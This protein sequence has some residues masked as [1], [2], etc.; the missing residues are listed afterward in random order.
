[1]NHIL[2]CHEVVKTD[3]VRG[4]GRYLYDAQG[5]RYV[6]FETGAWCTPLGHGTGINTTVFDRTSSPWESVWAVAIP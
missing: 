2:R 6:G 1:V 4:R 5:R 3:M